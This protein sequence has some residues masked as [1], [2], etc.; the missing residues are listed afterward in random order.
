[1]PLDRY[2]YIRILVTVIPPD[3]M[4]QYNLADLVEDG[5]VMVEIL[6]G[7]MAYHRL[8]S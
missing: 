1:M 5:F 4:D 3:I 2:E 8:A 7:S 6:K